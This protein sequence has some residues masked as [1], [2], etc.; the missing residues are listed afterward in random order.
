VVLQLRALILKVLLELE[1]LVLK[2][3]DLHLLWLQ[4]LLH[5]L[6]TVGQHMLRL[7]QVLYLELVLVEIGLALI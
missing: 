4:A 1:Q 3:I 5:F 2:V 7:L 6:R